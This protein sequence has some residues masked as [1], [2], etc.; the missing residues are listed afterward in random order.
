MRR[1]HLLWAAIALV[2]LI[3]TGASVAFAMLPPSPSPYAPPQ[4]TAAEAA[5]TIA[6]LKPPKRARPVIAVIGINDATETT[7]YLMP[8]SILRRAEVGEVWALATRSGPVQLFPALRVLPDA[9]I[10]EFDARYPTGA[11]YV[12]VPKMSRDDDPAALAWIRRQAEQGAIIIGVCAGAPTVA[13]AGLLDGRQATTHWFYLRG[14]LKA[15]PGIRYVKDR[16]FVVDGPVAT[17]TGISASM[18]MSLTLIEAI[19]GRS[20]AEAVARSLGVSEWNARHDSSA[21]RL[22]RRFGATVIG[23]LLQFWRRETLGIAVSAGQDPVSLAL[24]TDAWSRTYRSRAISYAAGPGPVTVRDGIRIAP[25]GIG[26]P[27]PGR[28]I[29]LPGETASA[30]LDQTLADIAGRYGS[31]AAQVVAMQLEYPV[32]ASGTWSSGR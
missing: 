27:P 16:R 26:V 8:T 30:V 6:A 29:S 23:N 9:T 20:K 24:A 12:I 11:D 17:T 28:T 10:A 15:H 14:M 5:R 7:D 4:I 13:N 3:V 18:P 2:A 31:G 32:P 25:D 21:F 22:N 1:R 19:A